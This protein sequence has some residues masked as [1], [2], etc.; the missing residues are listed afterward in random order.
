MKANADPAPAPLPSTLSSFDDVVRPGDYTILVVD[1]QEETRVSTR[2]LLE[3]EGYQVRTANTGTEALALFDPEHIDLVILDYLMPRM[4]SARLIQEIRKRDANVHIL[5]QT[6]YAGEETPREMLQ[7]LNIQGYHNKIDG[8]DRLLL[9]IKTI[10]RNATL[11][12][13]LT[14]E[15]HRAMKLYTTLHEICMRLHFILA[16]CRCLLDDI[17]SCETTRAESERRS[18]VDRQE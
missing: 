15:Q 6:G 9:W 8:P 14:Q 16:D 13:K 18:L 4:N 7:G 2:L 10:G 11:A 1:D 12:K 5:L 17:Q 3:S